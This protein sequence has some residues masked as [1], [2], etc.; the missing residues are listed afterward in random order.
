MG[1]LAYLWPLIDDNWAALRPMYQDEAYWHTLATII[2]QSNGQISLRYKTRTKKQD[3][4][5]DATPTSV[6]IIT[7]FAIYHAELPQTGIL[8]AEAA[9]LLIGLR[10]AP[11]D[12]IVH[13]DNMPLYYMLRNHK[14]RNPD[15][16]GWITV[17]LDIMRHRNLFVRWIPSE[18][19]P[20]DMPSRCS[21]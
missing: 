1:F 5:V 16:Y 13:M 6:G 19:N 21:C 20:A 8:N 2:D 15:L 3:I 14:T 12:S 11:K 10:M 17:C 9:A 7:Q 18:S 4:F